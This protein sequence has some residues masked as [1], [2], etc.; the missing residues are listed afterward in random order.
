MAQSLLPREID[1]YLADLASAQV[2]DAVLD[3]MERRAEEDGFP[4]V[5]RAVG[6]YLE[7]QARAI[8]ARRVVELGS[9]YGYSGYWF[10]RAVGPDGEV[11]CTEVDR[12]RA[13]LAESYLRRA[14]LWDR[15][16][17]RVGD[18]L[19]T[20]AQVDGEL[21]VVFCDL[22]KDRYPAAWEAAR[23][24]L[25]IGGL[26]LC[27]NVLW[28]GRVAGLPIDPAPERDA[29]TADVVAMTRAALA[30][31]RYVTTLA[32]IRDGVLVALRVS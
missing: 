13:T 27:D 32:P 30:D 19:E 9:G 11:V 24:R 31:E 3:D 15:I 25:R 8:G 16:R 14:G 17:Y 20:L 12:D 18:A 28:D 26:F 21:D 1:G 29:V 5:G 22:P 23:E 6:R 4:I 7:V 10:A 2:R